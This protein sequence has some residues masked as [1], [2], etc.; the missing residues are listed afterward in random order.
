[1][2]PVKWQFIRFLLST[3]GERL[4]LLKFEHYA[5]FAQHLRVH[6]QS[7]FIAIYVLGNQGR[8]WIGGRGPP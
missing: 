6:V 7:Y 1:M 2:V 3:K 4:N 5:Y 8:S